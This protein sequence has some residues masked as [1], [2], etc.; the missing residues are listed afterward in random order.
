MF[1]ITVYTLAIIFGFL[2][3]RCPAQVVVKDTYAP[4]EPIVIGCNCVTP[5][6]AEVKYIW[7]ATSQAKIVTDDGR[8]YVWAPPGQHSVT[9]TVFWIDFAST[10]WDVQVYDKAF[11]VSGT[12]T[13]GPEPDPGPNPGPDP[14]KPN[15]D[16]PDGEYG[17]TKLAFTSGSKITGDARKLAA[18]LGD[19]FQAVSSALAAGAYLNT[20]LAKA[21]LQARNSAVVGSHRDAWLES[22]FKPIGERLVELESDGTLASQSNMVK[23][24]KAVG[25][26]L[27][28]IK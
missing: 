26:G 12:P 19:N 17:L 6:G 18:D 5:E 3:A 4:Y 10:T 8:A 11:T 9:V 28:L 13:P 21:D 14:P 27:K 15:P 2:C 7:R 16:V 25:D 20:G 1:R 23:A 22:F 24:L